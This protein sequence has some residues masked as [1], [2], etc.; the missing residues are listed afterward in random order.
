VLSLPARHS[1][2]FFVLLG[3]VA[4][5]RW[6]WLCFTRLVSRVCCHAFV[7]YHGFLL[8]KNSPSTTWNRPGFLVE[9]AP[10]NHHLPLPAKH[11]PTST[12][13]PCF[14]QFF[15]FHALLPTW[16]L[17]LKDQSVACCTSYTLLWAPHLIILGSTL[18]FDLDP[19]HL[20]HN[21]YQIHYT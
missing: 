3:S 1:C 20:H 2:S 5:F 14:L 13:N 8:V 7:C 18:G 6:C 9:Q 15:I 4:L 17:N 10:T 19:L 11:L 12:Y 21:P 16:V